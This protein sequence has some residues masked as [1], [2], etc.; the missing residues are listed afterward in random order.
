VRFGLFVVQPQSAF[1]GIAHFR[2]R[3]KRRHVSV[4]QPQ[5][6]FRNPRPG[7]TEMRVFFHGTLKKFKTSPQRFLGALVRVKEA[8]Q[9]IVV[10]VGAA[11]W[12]RWCNRE[13]EF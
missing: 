4:R 8:L 9:I 1:S 2:I 13:L 11:R 10:S 5:P 12:T 6:R 3:F 7:A